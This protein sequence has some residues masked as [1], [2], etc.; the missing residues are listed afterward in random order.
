MLCCNAFK[1][2]TLRFTKRCTWRR[3][4]NTFL[5]R[6]LRAATRT[7][8]KRGAVVLIAPHILKSLWNTVTKHDEIGSCGE[9]R[10]NVSGPSTVAERHFVDPAARLSRAAREYH[11]IVGEGGVKS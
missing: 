8:G 11:K 4:V 5:K 10:I 7:G 3:R 6:H 9:Y 2:V 1:T